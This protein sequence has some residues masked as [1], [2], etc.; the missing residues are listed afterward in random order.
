M[1]VDQ[2]ITEISSLP[3]VE[4]VRVVQAIWDSL[5]GDPD[6]GVSADQQAELDRRVAAHDADPGSSISA[7]GFRRRLESDS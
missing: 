2:T 4:R 5:P 6:L 3:V 1:N 7:E